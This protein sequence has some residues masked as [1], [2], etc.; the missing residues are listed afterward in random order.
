MPTE[1]TSWASSPDVRGR[2]QRQRSEGTNPELL[3]RREL[4]RRGLRFRVHRRLVLGMRHSTD[5]VFGPAK[6]AVYVDGC[7]WHGCPEHYRPPLSNPG[8]WRVKIERNQARD[9]E[10]GRMLQEAGWAVV[11]VWEHD[12]VVQAAARVEAIVRSRRPA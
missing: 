8:Y 10:T 2:M 7:F 4:H 11:R 1:P 6:V 3:L 9:S 12:D 5:I